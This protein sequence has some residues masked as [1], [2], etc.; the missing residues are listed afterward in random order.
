MGTVVNLV[1]NELGFPFGWRISVGVPIIIGSVLSL[2]MLLLPRSPRL[3]VCYLW[4][5][6]NIVIVVVHVFT[7]W[8]AKRHRDSE[9]LKVLCKIYRDPTR[10]QTQLEEIQQASVSSTREPFIQTLKYI[11]QWKILQRYFLQQ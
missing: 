1:V 9:A 7:R 11:V 3:C 6:S 8:L 5:V 2:G 10:A 4:K